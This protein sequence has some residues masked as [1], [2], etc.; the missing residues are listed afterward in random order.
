MFPLYASV[1][2]SAVCL[3]R[4]DMNRADAQVLPWL[5]LGGERNAN[6]FIELRHRTAVASP[7]ALFLI[8]SRAARCLTSY[9]LHT[10]PSLRHRDA[11]AHT[12]CAFAALIRRSA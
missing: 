12:V 6:N 8:D 5:F 2:H 1:L 3:S 10:L 7:D 4:H 9:F 11:R